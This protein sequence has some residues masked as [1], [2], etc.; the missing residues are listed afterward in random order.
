MCTKFGPLVQDVIFLVDQSKYAGLASMGKSGQVYQS[1][2]MQNWLYHIITFCI[3]NLANKYV[4]YFYQQ[5]GAE[6]RLHPA[7]FAFHFFTFFASFFGKKGLV[8]L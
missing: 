1:I 8:K 7:K 2:T 4:E 6:L 3:N 5:K